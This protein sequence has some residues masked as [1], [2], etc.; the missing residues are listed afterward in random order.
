MTM[1]ET[2]LKHFKEDLERASEIYALANT[3]P[4]AR[5][6]KKLRR[7]DIFRSAWMFCVGAMDAYFCDAYVDVLARTLRAMKLQRGIHLSEAVS[8]IS[9]PIG[10]ILSP[11]EIR[12]NWVWRSAAKDLIERESVLSLKKIADLFR[13][14]LPPG[15][16]L[17]ESQ[18]VRSLIISRSPPTRMVGISKSQLRALT[19][20]PL[21]EA[22]KAVKKQLEGRIQEIFQRRHDCIHNCDR[23]KKSPQGMTGASCKKVLNDV[24]LLV[25]FC[26]DHVEEAFNEYLRK[27][28]AS[29]VTMNKVGY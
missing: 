8:K 15:K 29:G 5:A 2:A 10:T 26:D 3:L 14:F 23:P 1:P 27:A 21:D 12:E 7:D 18:V 19:G 4:H 28:G 24:D 11:P 22:T 20:R 16:K 13:P 9:L 25:Q 6:S 17:F